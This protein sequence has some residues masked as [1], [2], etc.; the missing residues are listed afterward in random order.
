M[1]LL[2]TFLLLTISLTA[3]AQSTP[4][5]SG[6]LKPSSPSKNESW[7]QIDTLF[8]SQKP[9]TYYRSKHVHP[10]SMYSDST[11]I[12]VIV[13]NSFPKGG[14]SLDD[15]GKPGYNDPSGK[16]FGYVIFWTR[17]INESTAP[18]ELT[19]NFPADSF[20]I[21]P[22][23]DAYVKVFLP[24]DTMTPDKELLLNYGI[25]GLKSF[26]DTG[27]KN[28][29]MVQRTINPKEEWFVYTGALGYEA[30]GAARAE[31]VIKEQEL[32][33]RISIGPYFEL[34]P[35]GRIVLKN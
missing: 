28:P 32:F 15:S 25:T 7:N 35:C 30:N 4:R 10:E 27:L 33:Y 21:F 17:I 22:S 34:I 12:V 18:L 9:L 20:A 1:K 19:I 3:T 6:S 14:V 11:G 24:P 13:Q 31:L 5:L 2:I 16:R 26:L 29:T 23:P 8:L